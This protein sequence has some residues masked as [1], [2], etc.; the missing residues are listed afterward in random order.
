MYMGKLALIAKIG[1]QDTGVTIPL[2]QYVQTATVR[3]LDPGH[4]EQINLDNLFREL[5]HLRIEPG[6]LCTDL[7]IICCTMYAADLRI[8][9]AKHAEDSWTR[10]IDLFIP[11]SDAVFWN[12]QKGLLC[13]IFRFLTGDIWNLEFRTRQYQGSIIPKATWRKF[14]L[15]YETDTVCLFSGGMDSFIGAVDLLDKGM[16]PLLLGHAKSADVSPY[17][18]YC[19]QALHT[20]FPGIDIKRIYASLRIPNQE[21]LFDGKE[22]TERGRSFLFLTLGAL[23]ASKLN[24]SSKLIVPENGFIS[25]NL[26]LTVLRAGAHSTRTTHPYYMSMM[27]NL[28]N[29]MRIGAMIE[30]PYQF[31]TK[32][33]MLSECTR[34]G[35]VQGTNTMSCSRPATRNARI[36]AAGTMHCGYCVPC[37][38]R[39]AAFN[40]AR[41]ADG[42]NYRLDIFDPNQISRTNKRENVISFQHLI[43]KARLNLNYITALIRATGPLGNGDVSGYIGV[44]NRGL[45]EVGNL[46]NRVTFV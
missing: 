2:G 1:P 9:R 15:P 24:P 38:I 5:K 37:L 12:G 45:A 30:N 43:E 8:N 44:Y 14:G 6:E 16:R 32:G 19:E 20:T 29:N 36:E 31:K 42:T 10:Q 41:I 27:Q 35:L 28:F 18:K 21:H 33:E 25:L 7:L 40:L 17:Q 11:V 23:C 46:V 4:P 22:S 39:Q 26:P 3:F 34:Q 13:N